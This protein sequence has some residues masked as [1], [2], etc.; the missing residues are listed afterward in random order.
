MNKKLLVLPIAILAITSLV[1]CSKEKKPE[2]EQG[3]SEPAE[4]FQ[5]TF[6][7]YDE[8]QLYVAEVVAGQTAVYQGE[9]PTKPST[10]MNDY[11][12][13]GWDKDLT[14]VQESF[15]TYAQYTE[16]LRK[17]TITFVNYDDSVLQNTK[18][19]YG[20][21]PSY[22]GAT[23]TK[24]SDANAD[25]TFSG[26]SPNIG[27]VNGDQT[28]KAVYDASYSPTY[29]TTGLVY[30]IQGYNESYAV[31]GYFGN[32]TTVAIPQY[33]DGI[34]VKTIKACSFSN[35]DHLENVFIP[36]TVTKIEEHA[37]DNCGAI[38]HITIGEGNTTYFIDDNGDLASANT[39]VYTLPSHSNSFEV[40]DQYTT[41][42]E[43]AFSASNIDTLKICASSF[44][45]LPELFAVD[46]AHM[47]ERL[48]SL[49]IKGGDISDE[50]FMDCQY[51]QSISLLPTQNYLPVTRVGHRAFKGCIALNSLRFP[52]S[53]AFI[54]DEAF[55][56]CT[57]MT[58]I[59][60]GTTAN[61]ALSYVG[62]DA[63]EGL[64]N[65]NL[66]N[67]IE[68]TNLACIGNPN[69]KAI[70]AM[71]PESKTSSYA[72]ISEDTVA[73]NNRLFANCTNLTEV[74]LNGNKL[75][76]VG[77]NLF[78]G[79]TNLEELHFHMN[80]DDN[81]L[82]NVKY[83]PYNTFDGCT[84]LMSDSAKTVKDADSEKDFF[85]LVAGSSSQTIGK[86]ILG[87]NQ[88]AFRARNTA[89]YSLTLDENNKAFTA[90]NKILRDAF[91]NIYCAFFNE[92]ST[93]AYCSGK[94]IFQKAFY[95]Q[96]IESIVLEEGLLY[97]NSSAF[98]DAKI[99]DTKI[100][101]PESLKALSSEAFSGTKSSNTG[102]TTLSIYSGSNLLSIG[103]HAFYGSR[104]V[105]LYT[106]LEAKP[107]GWVSGFDTMAE[108]YYKVYI[109]Y[110]YGV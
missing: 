68:G 39:L 23:P 17:Y 55:M 94:N 49:I 92:E 30:Q 50:Q 3:S 79:C 106:P 5:V 62:R 46:A 43:G 101:L 100:V 15:T 88:N 51:L 66:Y 76:S 25:Y 31:V 21:T 40:K 99:E 37:F 35:H 105:K 89:S 78:N 48:K 41:V 47:P 58:N 6:K 38:N 70:I 1:G 83:L 86:D 57:A 11:V 97:I 110:S 81:Y 69:C 20:S 10:V 19:E 63:F 33:F 60:I 44:T 84:K 29:R 56:G 22:N 73:L 77:E 65:L 95:G 93:V 72:F 102:V 28:Y 4:V 18:E 71:E 14:N 9:E 75:V 7:N 24:P 90:D 64:D 96:N 103:W 104:D 36:R 91:G 74:T 54:G 67:N 107:D 2:S 13:N 108:N 34:P 52:D 85:L 26:W 32:E 61:V 8:M 45:T 16:Q 87:I 12:F 53:L 82:E 59:Q 27:P 109:T 80:D 42:L 98:Q